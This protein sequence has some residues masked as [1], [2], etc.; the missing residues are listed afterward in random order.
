MITSFSVPP[1]LH[2]LLHRNNF[3]KLFWETA[4]PRHWEWAMLPVLFL[5]QM[6]SSW[7]FLY[8]QISGSS[9][10]PNIWATTNNACWS[11][12]NEKQSEGVQCGNY[13]GS[14]NK[15]LKPSVLTP[16]VSL[17]SDPSAY[18][19]GGINYSSQIFKVIYRQYLESSIG[20]NVSGDLAIWVAQSVK[21]LLLAQVMI[22]G[23]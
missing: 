11:K 20:M 8:C 22:P 17:S 10:T 9:T 18:K 14:L 16:N 21:H 6:R 5:H 13:P 4:V 12:V 1:P 19:D 2:S 23:S 15:S 7:Y 3:Q